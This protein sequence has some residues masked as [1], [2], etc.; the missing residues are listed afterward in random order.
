[1]LHLMRLSS[2]LPILKG[3]KTLCILKLCYRIQPRW[4]RLNCLLSEQMQQSM[5]EEAILYALTPS[6]KLNNP[7]SLQTSLPMGLNPWML[8][9]YHLDSKK[10]KVNKMAKLKNLPSPLNVGFVGNRGI[11]RRTASGIRSRS[12]LPVPRL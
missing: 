7:S 3:L 10:V 11:C 8:T 4:L 1:M 6:K 2:Y 9:N 12:N 5:A